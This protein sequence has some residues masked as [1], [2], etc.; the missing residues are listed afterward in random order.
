MAAGDGLERQI[1]AAR[2]FAPGVE[3]QQIKASVRARLFGTLDGAPTLGGYT[4]RRM[5]GRG[6]MGAVF[7]AV[8]RDGDAVALK[9]LRGFDPAALYR[10]KLEFRALSDIA[11]PNLALLHNLVVRG[12]QAFLTMELVDGVDF[13]AHVRDGGP[14]APERLRAAL[15]QL[16]AG[17]AALHA[18]GKLHRD[19]K[20]SNVL[21]TREGRVVIL[22][23]GLVHELAGAGGPAQ[24]VGTPAYMAPEQLLGAPP[25][26][27]SDWYAVGVML[28]EALTG[29][30][31][32]ENGGD[33][34][35]D[36]CERD[37]PAPPG[38]PSLAA[39]CSAL[40]SRK[41]DERPGGPEIA[42]RLAGADPIALPA[43][44]PSRA[45]ARAASFGGL[46]GREAAVAALRGALAESVRGPVVVLVLGRSG[47]GKSA[48]IHAF[49]E[50]AQAGAAGLAAPALVL[51]GRCYEREQVPY[52]A[53]DSAID[54][55][56]GL[57]LGF[58][59]GELAGVLPADVAALAQVFP[60][61]RRVTAIA[62]ACP[63]G[64]PVEADAA[65]RR[66]ASAAL[67]DMFRRLGERGPLVLALDDVQWTDGDS[68]A[69][70]GE[71][72][73]GP[74]APRGLVILGASVDDVS[75]SPELAATLARLRAAAVPIREVA[76]GPLRAEQA[77][78]LAES[79]LRRGAGELDA[80]ALRG[81][82]AVIAA[83]AG[84][85]PLFVREL[86]Y[87]VRTNMSER[88]D[89]GAARLEALVAARVARLSWPAR[90][91]IEAIAVAGRPLELEVAAQVAEA[92]GV[93]RREAQELRAAH[94]VR[95]SKSPRGELV[96]AY[97]DR[98]RAAVAGPIPDERARAIHRRLADVLLARPGVPPELLADHLRAA[99]DRARAAEVTR[100][101][102][103]RAVEALALR[104]A[105]ELYRQAAALL[106]AEDVDGR[107]DMFVRAG[108][109]L[110]AAGRGTEAAECLL[111][112]TAAAPE[113]TALG[114]RRRA[115]EEL[116]RGGAIARGRELLL[117]VMRDL[118][119]PMP[120]SLAARTLRQVRQ[121]WR[122]DRR[123]LAFVPRPEREIPQEVLLR[124]DALRTAR[125][126]ISQLDPQTAEMYIREHLLQCLDVGEPGRVAR[127]I[128]GYAA[129]QSHY[130]ERQAWARAAFAEARALIVRHGCRD[131]ALYVALCAGILEHNAGCF[132]PARAAF[133]GPEIQV[134]EDS[135]AA[136]PVGAYLAATRAVWL[137]S[138]L[139]HL[140]DARALTAVRDE[141]AAA[142]RAVG[143]PEGALRLRAN[144]GVLASLAADDPASARQDIEAAARW[145]PPDAFQTERGHLFLAARLTD[146]YEGTGESAWARTQ[147]AWP[148]FA[149]GYLFHGQFGRVAGAYWRAATA[150][151]AARAGARGRAQLAALAGRTAD[152]LAGEDRPWATAL[153]HCLRAASA[154]LRG[155]DDRAAA[156]LTLAAIRLDAA[157]LRLFA[158]A[159][160]WHRGRLCGGDRG[161]AMVATAEAAMRAAGVV[162]PA[163]LA[164]AL[165]PGFPG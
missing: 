74:A 151:Q 15:A 113:A 51:A 52:N 111:A 3:I 42:A 165:I 46:I 24:V 31:P 132:A 76:L 109:A 29:R 106:P 73:V 41:P 65:R 18:A 16:V 105:A 118:G 25:S 43:Q 97:H 4:L 20:P 44:T 50:A 38:D 131:V 101:A 140:G 17:L 91:M 69:L 150:L 82:A 138:A 1:Q 122:L 45:L 121:R 81:R 80:A 85:V 62:E 83:E 139:A 78:A 154:S 56:A 147:R 58:G 33:L 90:Q 104:R 87:H 63:P 92:G 144:L 108:E 107:R 164:V 28:F 157:D 134:L 9:V 117:Q 26:T 110:A 98:I 155:R 71:L 89:V 135:R 39:L 153:G 67:Q 99:G 47:M 133:V 143:D 130:A 120:T 75:T 35:R 125:L 21:V 54:A 13:L 11:H 145:L 61:L 59:P 22:D 60:V 163:R 86:A 7:E 36:K 123:G 148:E 64:P 158:A 114:L 141:G 149:R 48:L 37:A 30:L 68:A 159:A 27:A 66:Q 93:G 100:V 77:A 5:I 88:T 8:G 53:F 10:F 161:A 94:L 96:E 55:L 102:A 116:L 160:R 103:Q 146:L 115:A 128:A 112:A 136:G 126:A 6:G 19:I 14:G 40:L 57:L 12:D 124:L 70:L 137:H 23:F 129:Y 34:L 152:A 162:A 119:E 2:E 79:L 142:L 156:E 127:A 84:G 32:F 49:A 72:L 95:A